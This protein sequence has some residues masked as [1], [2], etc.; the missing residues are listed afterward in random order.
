M[1]ISFDN[2][3][4]GDWYSRPADLSPVESLFYFDRD[5]AH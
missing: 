4:F 1:C 5:G 2:K 3:F